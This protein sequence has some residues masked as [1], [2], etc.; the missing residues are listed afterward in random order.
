MLRRSDCQY[1]VL[2]LSTHEHLEQSR[3]VRGA[4]PSDR[5]P[6]SGSTTNWSVDCI[7]GVYSEEHL[8]ETI[9]VTARVTS[10]CNVVEGT[11]VSIQSWVD[12]A[13]SALASFETLL[14]NAS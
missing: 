6:A 5:I 3:I 10:S 4:E 14:I 2:R 13:D 9:C 11:W 12:K 8:R 7:F 1:S